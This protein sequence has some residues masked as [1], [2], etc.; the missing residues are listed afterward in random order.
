MASNM[1]LAKEFDDWNSA[2]VSYSSKSV[3]Q[4]DIAATLTSLLDTGKPLSNGFGKLIPDLISAV[5]SSEALFY[6]NFIHMLQFPFK[7]KGSELDSVFREILISEAIGYDDIVRWSEALKQSINS[8]GFQYDDKKL[9]FVLSFMLIIAIISIVQLIRANMTFSLSRLLEFVF[10]ALQCLAQSTTSF[11][12]EEQVVSQLCFPILFV[13]WFATSFPTFKHIESL[14]AILFIN[15]ILMSWSSVGTL[16]RSS[17]SISDFVKS[18]EWLQVGSVVLSLLLIAVCLIKRKCPGSKATLVALGFANF[19][20]FLNKIELFAFH[21]V[22]TARLCLFSVLYLVLIER[23]YACLTYLLIVL[24]RPTHSL[25]IVILFIMFG[26]MNRLQNNSKYSFSPLLIMSLALNSFYALGLWN[27]VSAVD[28]TFGAA[29]TSSF[30]MRIAPLVLSSY[31]FSGP[32]LA[33]FCAGFSEISM[34]IHTRVVLDFFAC[35][36]AFQ[37]RYHSWIFDFFAPKV[38][39]QLLWSAFFVIVH[40]SRKIQLKSIQ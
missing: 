25:A 4:E 33:F 5:D 7:K 38:L 10:L 12:A 39:F 37:H 19:S 23:S 20:T 34:L 3:H 24:N 36:F 9:I 40:F 8:A 6:K 30:D 21:R 26:E 13:I 22:L 18:H 29:F 31:F 14:L 1:K 15:R 27:S 11:I 32:L 2:V 16:W 35:F 17:I 28:L